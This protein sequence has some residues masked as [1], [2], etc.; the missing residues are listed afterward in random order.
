[1]D[2][3]DA[4]RGAKQRAG[5]ALAPTLRSIVLHA[6]PKLPIY[7]AGTVPALI[8]KS[9]GARR[10]AMIVLTGFAMLSLMLALL[11]IY[12]ADCCTASGTMIP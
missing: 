3:R 6:D 4:R 12:G 1:M 10:L 9:L 8:D 2:R 11:G 5:G 7:E